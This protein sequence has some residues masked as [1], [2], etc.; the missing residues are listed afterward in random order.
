MEEQKILTSLVI[1]DTVYT[2]KLTNK[3]KMRKQ[4]HA[5]E[6]KKITA[7][8]PGIIR[9]ISIKKGQH[10]KEG[11]KLLILEAMKMKNTVTSHMDGRIKEVKVQCGDMVLKNQLLIELE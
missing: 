5:P 9:D 3:Y 7:F 10:V 6:P 1:D 4:Y 11:D 2:T 8:I